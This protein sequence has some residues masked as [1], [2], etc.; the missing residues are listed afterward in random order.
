M[1]QAVV[2][3]AVTTVMGDFE[4][5]EWAE[6]V[7]RIMREVANAAGP[8][9]CFPPPDPTVAAKASEAAREVK[10]MTKTDALI[11]AQ[12]L[13]DPESQK[14][15]T[16]GNLILDSRWLEVEEARMRN[17]GERSE[18]LRFSEDLSRKYTNRR[19]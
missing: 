18:R 11:V 13:M 2:G 3:E 8:A 16:T 19:S 6:L 4:S 7:G 5:G 15:L 9:T 12:A 14:L 10:G 1:P 17:G